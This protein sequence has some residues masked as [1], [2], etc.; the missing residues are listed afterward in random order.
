M[1]ACPH[2]SLIKLG[3]LTWLTHIRVTFECMQIVYKERPPE[4]LVPIATN[5]YVCH[6]YLVFQLEHPQGHAAMTL[7]ANDSPAVVESPS[8]KIHSMQKAPE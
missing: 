8:L 2:V 5:M 3:K 7:H 4:P 1:I 6:I